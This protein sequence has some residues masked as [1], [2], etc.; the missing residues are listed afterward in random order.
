MP[1]GSRRSCSSRRDIKEMLTDWRVG[2]ITGIDDR[3]VHLVQGRGRAG[4]LPVTLYFD[5]ESG[6]LV[7]VLHVHVVAGRDQSET[8]RLCGL[9]GGGG[10]R[11]QDAVSLDS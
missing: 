1:P 4:G 3:D 2:P 10:D 9:S 7:R 6:L 5:A 8:D 11:R